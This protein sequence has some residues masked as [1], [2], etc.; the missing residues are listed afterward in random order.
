MELTGMDELVLTVAEALIKYY[1]ET[2]AKIHATVDPL[3]DDEIWTKPHEYGN[4]IGHLL[5]HQTGNLNDRIGT[6]VCGLDYKRNRALEFTDTQRRNK[7]DLL[8]DFDSAI[9]IV[10]EAIRGQTAESWSGPYSAQTGPPAPSRLAIF[11][12]CLTHCTHHLGQMI[13]LSKE[14]HRQAT[15]RG[16]ACGV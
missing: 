15:N 6:R 16:K 7:Q 12:R 2:V 10:I 9:S 3:S 1:E 5:L 8:R 13:Y 14:L 4:S 11:V